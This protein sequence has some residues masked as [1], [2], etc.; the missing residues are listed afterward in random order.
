MKGKKLLP[1]KIL[2]GSLVAASMSFSAYG[3][4]S[5]GGQPASFEV[6]ENQLRSGTMPHVI[7]VIPDF[8]VED[9]RSQEAWNQQ[10]LHVRP[11]TIGKVIDREIDFA[12]EAQKVILSNGQTI[13]RLTIDAP[14]AKG[15][16]LMYK[17]FFIPQGAGEL[18]IYTPDRRE[19]LGAYTFDTHSTHGEFAT[20]PLPGSSVILEFVPSIK[21]E[22]PSIL[23][24]GIAY[25]FVDNVVRD[26]GVDPGEDNSQE[27]CQ[28]NINCPQGADWQVQ[29]AGVVQMYM[30][31]GNSYGVCSGN[32]LNNTAKDFKPYIIT[33]AHCAGQTTNFSVAQADLN[34]WVFSFHYEKPGCSNGQHA[35]PRR[36]TMTG[37]SMRSYLPIKGESD[38]MLLELKQEIPLSYRVYYNG[39]DRT[40]TLINK[41]AGIHHPKGD[42]KKIS[43][44]DE[45]TTDNSTWN[46]GT[47]QGAP[48]AHFFFRYKEGGTEGGS[49]GSSLFN[50]NKLVVGTLT[51]GSGN[52]CNGTEFYGK[53]QYHWD[54]F[55]KEG[56]T[57][58][59]MASFLD[60]KNTNEMTLQGTWRENLRPLAPITDLKI[61]REGDNIKVT[62]TPVDRTELPKEWEIKYRIYRNGKYLDGKDVTEGTTFSEPI[63]EALAGMVG[64]VIYGVQARYLYKKAVITTENYGDADIIQRGVYTGKRIETVSAKSVANTYGSQKGRYITWSTPNNLQE[65]SLF[66]YPSSPSF[67]AVRLPYIKPYLFTSLPTTAPKN[68]VT[69]TKYPSYYFQNF[70]GNSHHYIYAVSIIPSD[71][72]KDD[73]KIFIRSGEYASKN[74]R[75]EPFDVPDNWKP[76]EWITVKLKTPFK[77]DPNKTLYIGFAAKN[78][79]SKSTSSGVMQVI[80]SENDAMPYIDGLAS[81]DEG[82]TFY[83][84]KSWGIMSRGYLAVRVT[85]SASSS[86]DNGENT[87]VFSRS[88]QPVP[89]PE[90]KGYRIKRDGNVI[91]EVGQVREYI[92]EEGTE[93]S[94]YEIEVIYNDATFLVANDK[95]ENVSDA[96]YVFPSTLAANAQLNIANH[97]EVSKVLVYTIDG[98]LVEQVSKPAESISL[99]QL[100]S[101]AYI[102]VLETTQG[103]ISQRIVR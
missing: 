12:K 93:S 27:A 9:I 31:Q 4:I 14:G 38:G 43:I 11:L 13:Y 81:F 21:N 76:N 44:L 25:V 16:A 73:Y 29:K 42:A 6:Q 92:D 55:K 46:D 68:A 22:L 102:V 83:P 88:S 15:T 79:K 57:S 8:N 72:T 78:D 59:Q 89:F 74:V 66:G 63:S 23:I 48:K 39:W 90:I 3:Q 33:A 75:L 17:D 99:E 84:R 100:T 34:K 64:N 47:N 30:A 60:P 19:L 49:S 36:K 50:N 51:G 87:A 35:L 10:Q 54:K 97:S 65:I 70:T 24:S 82:K 67:A 45:Q 2:M 32:L 69:A 56:Q 103:R 53:L 91:K 41:G 58:T 5:F 98:K 71:K 80:N 86:A 61:V 37:C 85:V 94:K 101:G 52:G 18:F 40:G 26:Y 7:R 28:V 95:V 96:P 77:V 1:A 62:W 20:E